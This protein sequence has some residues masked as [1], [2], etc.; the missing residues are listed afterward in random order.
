MVENGRGKCIT[1]ILRKC[2]TKL[3]L[4]INLTVLTRCDQTSK[5]KSMLLKLLLFENCP[6]LKRIQWL[7]FH[8]LTKHVKSTNSVRLDC[9]DGIVHVVGRRCWRRQVIDLVHCEKQEKNKLHLKTGVSL[10]SFVLVFCKCSCVEVHDKRDTVLEL[11]IKC[12][13][14]NETFM[15]KGSV[16]QTKTCISRPLLSKANYI[17]T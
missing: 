8:V 9:F 17:H 13:K 10:I 3:Y 2:N 14:N 11:E 15:N 6:T 7:V 16:N 4:I 12:W 1:V 5:C